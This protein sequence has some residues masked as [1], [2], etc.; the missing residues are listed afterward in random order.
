MAGTQEE[1]KAPETKE[2]AIPPAVLAVQ[3]PESLD[4][5]DSDSPAD[6][7]EEE[8]A[9]SEAVDPAS[10]SDEE[11]AEWVSNATP[12]QLREFALR[13]DVSRGTRDYSK[14][15][16]ELATAEK[17]FEARV[18]TFLQ[19]A[20]PMPAASGGEVPES[21]DT[22]PNYEYVD[23]ALAT[24]LK[25]IEQLEARTR[26]QDL[27]YGQQAL[28]RDIAAVAQEH[29]FFSEMGDKGVLQLLQHMG[30][31]GT[32]SP[33]VAFN[34][35]FHEEI[36]DEAVEKR[37]RAEREQQARAASVPPT[38]PRGGAKKVKETVPSDS[39]AAKNMLARM[40]KK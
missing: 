14:K 12:E 23:P 40:L 24:V 22:V 39:V 7:R 18:L 21:A 17:D 33:K 19:G 26:Q 30:Q 16:N 32:T 36:V 9:D 34:S 3:E 35:L 13:K 28:A 20:G 25:R 11:Y 15:R 5:A 10:L 4:E 8:P 38:A 37:L 27:M 29:P 2:P 6:A 31:I 1:E